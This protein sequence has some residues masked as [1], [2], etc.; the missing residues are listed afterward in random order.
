MKKKLL[1]Y[2]LEFIVIVASILASFWLNELSIKNIED[3]ETEKVLEHIEM[4]I[5][6]LKRYC[7]E[8]SG[9]WSQD[10][11]LYSSFL[12]ESLDLD[13]IKSLTTSK[14][15]IEYNLIYYRSFEPPMNRYHSI[16]NSGDIKLL[17]SDKLKEVLSRLHT[18]NYS[19]IEMT[20]QYEKS[21]KEHLVQ[22][23]TSKHPNIIL[24]ANDN[25]V[26]LEAF[27]TMLHSTI[28]QDLELKSKLLVQMKYF[29]T[30]KSLLKLYEF[31]LEELDSELNNVRNQS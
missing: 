31:A 29:E 28:Q 2:F 24:A 19:S 5:V 23:L 15:R 7:Q 16:I 11:S 1:I 26:T 18:Y 8:R 25:K 27:A 6:D 4:E 10:I 21:I 30:R 13:K 3:E 12:S 20:V 14:S 22:L 9:T 17:K